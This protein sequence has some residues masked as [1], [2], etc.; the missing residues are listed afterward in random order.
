MSGLLSH[1]I[2]L[3][4]L[5]PLVAG[6]LMLLFEARGRKFKVAINTVTTLTLLAVSC[7]L[8]RQAWAGATE[9]P[10][11]LVYALG[12]WA[13][14]VGIVLVLDQLSALMLLLTSTLAIA[15]LVYS[16]AR[17]HEAGVYFHPLFQFLLMGLNGTFLTG[18]L[19]NLFVFFEVMLGASYGLLLHGSGARRA[20]A[21]MHYIV[22]NLANSFLFL[23]GVALI[24]GVT[25]TLNM[26]D[27]ALQIA[28]LQGSDRVLFEVGAGLLGI[29]F[30]VK[31][32]MWP[33][34]FWLTPAYSAAVPPVAAL[35]AILSKVGIYVVLRLWLLM[36]GDHAGASEGF[37]TE[38]LYFG[39]LATIVFGMCSAL[40]SQ[41]S[42]RLASF[43]VLVSSGILLTAISFNSPAVTAGALFYLINSTLAISAF[44]LLLHVLERGR[45]VGA[46]LLAVTEEAFGIPS[47]EEDVTDE[48][49]VVVPAAMAILGVSFLA[50][51][52]LLAGLPPLSGFIAKFVMLTALLNPAG[53]PV[54]H[55][56]SAAD[57]AF[58]ILVITSGL[59]VLIA[60][61]RAGMRYFWPAFERKVPRIS[62][63]ELF[64]VLGLLLLCLV[65]TVAAGP[66]MGFLEST[67]Q[68]LHQPQ[69]YID[70]V[71]GGG[72][73]AEVTSESAHSTAEEG[74]SL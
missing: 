35:F 60:L 49:G 57:W 8:F 68:T 67:A 54:E 12:D 30:L 2:I 74:G 69:Y 70:T 27:V 34:N 24:Y 7:Y 59:F 50:C 52:V 29:A 62:P 28:G 46:D 10:Q 18:D 44:F 48:A 38:W 14:P 56:A 42:G 65:L 61:T 40:A 73:S 39:G 31:A 23:L 43:C 9:G 45:S 5:L 22:F 58:L 4:V 20:K 71:M 3:P 19:F 66:V 63:Y 15:S 13:A 26:A 51:A 36:F 1:L 17:W 21:G 72:L 25:G 6:M 55:T 64:P 53:L 37:G 16:L 33:L 41:D 11:T 32:G 47:D